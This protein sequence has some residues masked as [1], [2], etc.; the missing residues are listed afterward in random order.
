MSRA[1]RLIAAIFPNRCCGC[2]A[3]IFTDGELCDNC[4]K[5]RA[6][7]AYER[8]FCKKCGQRRTE[9][10]CERHSFFGKAVFAFF[11]TDTVKR[12]VR[13][14]K[15]RGNLFYG[16]LFAKQMY[17]AAAESGILTDA[18]FVVPVPMHGLKKLRRGFNQTELLAREFSK[19]SGI[20]YLNALKKLTLSPSQHDLNSIE[21]AG[22]V[23]GTF[24]VRDKCADAVNGAKI[25]LVDDIMTTH[26]TMNEAAKTLFIFGAE[27]VDALAAAAAVKKKR[28]N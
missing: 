12:T 24:E 6:H 18:S 25:I 26:A 17:N 11:Y 15:F 27:K 10:I 5:C 20:P 16:R 2:G 8:G 3:V 28:K 19:I 23:A 7:F 14:F 9:C 4:E 22:N 21:R 13:Q 1:D